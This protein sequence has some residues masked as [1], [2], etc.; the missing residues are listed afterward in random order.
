MES[1]LTDPKIVDDHYLVCSNDPLSAPPKWKDI[2]KIG[3]I[4][5]GKAYVELY[6]KLIKKLGKQVLLP[7]IIYTDGTAT[8]QFLDLPVTP[9]KFTLGIFKRKA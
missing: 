2:G 4:N 3:D 9:F 5:T 1:L 8:G 7:I 6:A